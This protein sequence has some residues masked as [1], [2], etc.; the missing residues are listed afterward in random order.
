MAFPLCRW[1]R[2]SPRGPECFH[3][4]LK[5]LEIFQP[6]FPSFL[7]CTAVSFPF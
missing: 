7:E 2:R 3:E 5:Y 6:V 1:H 4:A